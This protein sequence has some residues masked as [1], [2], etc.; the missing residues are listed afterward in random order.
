L[1]NEDLILIV[2][3]NIHGDR[4]VKINELHEIIPEV[5]KSLVHVNVKERFHHRKLCAWW[6]PKF[7]PENHKE[8]RMGA[9]LTFLMPYSEECDEFLESIV[10]GDEMW[11]FTPH[12]KANNSQQSG[13]TLI[14]P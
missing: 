3:E 6:V 9:A 13:A 11:V 5:P 14:V 12:L 4:H 2:D 8:N 7:L 1:V 10:T